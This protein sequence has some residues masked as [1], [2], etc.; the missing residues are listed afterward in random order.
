[1]GKEVW[2]WLCNLDDEQIERLAKEYDCEADVGEIHNL[3]EDKEA[4]AIEHYIV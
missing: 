2:S 4:F 3:I 1:M